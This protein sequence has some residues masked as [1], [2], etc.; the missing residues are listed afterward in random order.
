MTN[1]MSDL[2]AQLLREEAEIEAAQ[3]DDPDQRD[4][5][6]YEGWAD[7]GAV[8]RDLPQD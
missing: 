2:E 6:A 5:T 7:A 3:A 1:E 8:P 4:L